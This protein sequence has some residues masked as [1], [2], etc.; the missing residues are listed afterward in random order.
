MRL[1][2]TAACALAAMAI[3]TT[4]D[5]ASAQRG[6]AA[7]P[8]EAQRPVAAGKARLRW[9]A[10]AGTAAGVGRVD[11]DDSETEAG[12]A[13]AGRPQGRT[14]RL[15]ATGRVLALTG[16]FHSLIGF[17]TGLQLELAGE[18]VISLLARGAFGG[19]DQDDEDTDLAGASLGYAWELELVPE[20]VRL[21]LGG[22]VGFDY[23]E[24]HNWGSSY[25]YTGSYTGSSSSSQTRCGTA[26]IHG[27]DDSS[28]EEVFFVTAA[29]TIHIGYAVAF[30]TLGPQLKIG[31]TVAAGFASG[32]TLRF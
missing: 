12:S 6:G 5:I 19:D 11:L 7:A 1:V 24:C 17:E 25:S 27:D 23:A 20:V 10:P 4:P 28:P 30:V 2:Y 8:A 29:P 32:V 15:R 22:Y 9:G 31:S 14:W 13:W 16:P 3:T 26:T 18:H 21:E